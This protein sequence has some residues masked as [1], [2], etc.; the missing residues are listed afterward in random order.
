MNDM[1]HTVVNFHP[2]ADDQDPTLCGQVL[3]QMFWTIDED[4]DGQLLEFIGQLSSPL[5]RE[6]LVNMFADASVM[7][8][9]D[10]IITTDKCQ[11]QLL[12][13]TREI[14]LS[15]ENG[16]IFHITAKT[17]PLIEGNEVSQM[18]NTA[19]HLIDANSKEKFNKKCAKMR[20]LGMIESYQICRFY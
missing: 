19:L 16:N 17:S 20:V 14:K 1:I 3:K 15:H 5:S 11:I 2:D 13:E 8:M 7:S 18:V 6:D 10:M 12:I 4:E 9:E